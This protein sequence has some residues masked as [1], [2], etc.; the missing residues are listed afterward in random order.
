MFSMLAG[1]ASTYLS[2]CHTALD[3]AVAPRRRV[4]IGDRCLGPGGGEA[5]VCSQGRL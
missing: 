3:H 4:Y 2:W 1:A 5:F